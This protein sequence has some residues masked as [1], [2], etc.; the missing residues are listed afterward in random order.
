MPFH[1]LQEGVLLW[2]GLL[3]V[4]GLIRWVWLLLSPGLLMKPI[5]HEVTNSVQHLLQN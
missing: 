1:Y 5:K 3:L 4:I 2:S